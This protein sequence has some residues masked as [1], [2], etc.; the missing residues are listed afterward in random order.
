MELTNEFR[1]PATVEQTWQVLTDVERVAP[2]LPG[3]QLT[4]IDG[5]SCNGNVK[6]KVGPIRTQ[7]NG[8]AHFSK[9]DR[10]AGTLVLM[11]EG[12]D[13]RG[14]GTAGATV[15]VELVEV[16]DG[17]QVTVVTNLQVTGRIAQFGRNV[18]VD[19]SDRLMAQFAKNLEAEMLG[20]RTVA[21]SAVQAAPAKPVDPVEST[22]RAASTRAGSPSRIHPADTAN[23]YV[24]LLDNVGPAIMKRSLPFAIP[25]LAMLVG[26]LIGHRR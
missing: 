6:V 12:R 2:C 17:T 10:D 14:Q 16:R 5:D 15:T 4:G 24:D 13:S 8:V 19:V 20:T 25:A 18:M 9:L 22:A 3:A 21:E 23:G 7:Y 1:V 26:W 11:A